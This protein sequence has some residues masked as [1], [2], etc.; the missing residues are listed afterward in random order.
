MPRQFEVPD[1]MAEFLDEQAPRLQKS[2]A[3]ALL[4]HL[5]DEFRTKTRRPQRRESV[6]RTRYVLPRKRK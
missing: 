6:A 4:L 1:D 3:R 5:I 2:D